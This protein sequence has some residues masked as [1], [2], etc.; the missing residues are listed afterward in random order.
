MIP[1]TSGTI[2]MMRPICKRIDVVHH[3]PAIDAVEF[4]TFPHTLTVETED[5]TPPRDRLKLCLYSPRLM[6]W[7]TLFT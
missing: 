2:A 4:W 1:L 7:V 3:R 6:L 5:P